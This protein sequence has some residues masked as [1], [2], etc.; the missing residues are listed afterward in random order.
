M[1]DLLKSMA[2]G[3]VAGGAA[4]Y[5]AARKGDKHGR[6]AARPVALGA[7]AGLAGG[8]AV[9]KLAGREPSAAAAPAA[10]ASWAAM[11]K[12]AAEHLVEVAGEGRQRAEPL[13]A[14]AVERSRQ[15]V[16]AAEQATVEAKKQSRKLAQRA[17]RR[18]AE[19]KKRSHKLAQ[20]AERR[21][22]EAKKR[23][24]KQAIKMVER[25]KPAVAQVAERILEATSPDGHNGK[26]RSSADSK[27]ATSVLE[28][29]NAL[30]EAVASGQK[31]PY[32][33]PLV[34]RLV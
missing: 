32:D 6:E 16:K 10:L 33:K 14:E 19:A 24:H 26:G 23:S 5:L 9:A 12:D 4:G 22:A 30:D 20:E 29:R 1:A 13:R 25:S 18:A 7:L 27:A 3:G 15:L 28:L 8:G 31:I 11:A 17:E 21:A 34:T 2:V